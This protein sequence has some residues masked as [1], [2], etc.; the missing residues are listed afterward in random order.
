MTTTTQLSFTE[1]E[2]LASHPMAEPLVLGGVV[3]HGGFDAE[4]KYVSPRT[5]NRVPAI[6]AWQ[7][8]RAADFATPVLDTPLATWPEHYPNFD[9]A[10]HLLAEGVRHPV[11]ATLTRIGTVEGFG[12]GIRYAPVPD[13]RALLQEEIDGTALDHLARGLYEAHARDE[14][15]HEGVAGHR[16]MWF[17]ARD[18]AFENPVTE[19][20]TELMIARMGLPAP[21]ADPAELRRRAEQA[22]VLSADIDFDLEMLITRMV[23]ILLIEISAFHTFAWAE[24]LLSEQSLVAGEG[25]AARLVSYIRQDE[26]PH[27]EYLKTALSEIRDRTVIGNS[28]RAYPGAD[29]VKTIWDICLAQSLGANRRQL[30]K[31]TV[32]EVE[33]GLDG[34]PRAAS[35]IEGFHALGSVDF[36][37]NGEPLIGALG[38]GG[39]A[40]TAST[41]Y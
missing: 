29:L 11:V 14:A 4:G 15:G 27:V 8:R 24:A 17:A 7:A 35:I 25:T 26:T 22:R 5:L 2:L 39:V 31:F 10:R 37:A 1:E 3:C 19:D 41:A 20:E 12:A 40:S 32:S 33:R 9:Q 34:H 6:E 13:L 18:I 28:G 30:I 36:D 23:R 38:S 16:E 21:G